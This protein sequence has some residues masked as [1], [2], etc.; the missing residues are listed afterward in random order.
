MQSKIVVFCF[1]LVMSFALIACGDNPLDQ[2]LNDMEK[3]VVKVEDLNKKDSVSS[4]EFQNIMKE[5]QDIG[6]KFSGA[7]SAKP[8]DAQMKRVQEIGTRFAT[9]IQAITPKVKM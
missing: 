8:S 4:A 5:F 2:A 3:I 6:T 1:M 9:A 7:A